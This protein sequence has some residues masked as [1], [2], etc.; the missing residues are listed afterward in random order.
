MWERTL[1]DVCKLISVSPCS[2]IEYETLDTKLKE[3]IA[4]LE[5]QKETL[6]EKVADLRRAVPSQAAEGFR[7]RWKSEDEAFE[8]QMRMLEDGEDGVDG[9][10]Q[11]G[12]LK[13]L[14]E[15]SNTWERATGGLVGLKTDLTETVA[16]LER[17]KGVVDHLE[18]KR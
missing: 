15:V 13:R 7:E 6:T 16:K 3:R 14:D 4:L 2:D 1:C 8:A 12:E 5:K 10:L 18:Q 17:A 9:S 11:L